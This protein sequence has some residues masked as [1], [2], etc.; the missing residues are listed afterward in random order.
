MRLCESDLFQTDSV[1]RKKAE[2]ISR[3]KEIREG[4]K[5]VNVS[6]VVSV[7]CKLAYALYPKA[8]GKKL[9]KEQKK[10]CIRIQLFP[11]L[12]SSLCEMSPFLVCVL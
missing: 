1:L 12:C 4:L 8:W 6:T 11:Q 7:H 2:L 5:E 3:G 10:S 9:T